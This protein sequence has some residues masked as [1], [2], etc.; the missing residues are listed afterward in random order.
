MLVSYLA[1]SWI[2]KKEAT[3]TSEI[4]VD[5]QWTTRLIS[6]EIELDKCV[7]YIFACAINMVCEIN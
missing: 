1:Y 5:S 3:Y 4:S 6:R 7:V 2:R